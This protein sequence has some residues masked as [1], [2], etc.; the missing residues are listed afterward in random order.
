MVIELKNID[1]SNIT[2]AAEIA[3][4]DEELSEFY[5]AF[6]EHLEKPNDRTEKHLIEEFWDVVQVNLSLLDKL[7]IRAD[8]VMKYYKEHLNK[9]E[10]RPR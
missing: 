5:E 8:K 10:H 2:L 3:K 1:V 4:H 9:I 6:Y 7:N